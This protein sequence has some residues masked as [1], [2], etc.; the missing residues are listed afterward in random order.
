MDEKR[1]SERPGIS[2]EIMTVIREASERGLQKSVQRD[3]AELNIP[4][5]RVHKILKVKL[6]QHA[7][8]IQVVQMLR[9]KDYHAILDV[10]QQ[11]RSTITESHKFLGPLTF[12]D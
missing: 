11:M 10:C 5:A 12:S 1:R 7:Y 8:K 4:Q 6:H 2:E 3:S 9:Q